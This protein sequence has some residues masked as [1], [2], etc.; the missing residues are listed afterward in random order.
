MTA[1]KAPPR[2]RNVARSAGPQTTNTIVPPIALVILDKPAAADDAFTLVSSRGGAVTKAVSE[3]KP[4]D[5]EHDKLPFPI[6]D[7]P[8]NPARYDLVQKRGKNSKNV[9]FRDVSAGDLVHKGE[10][11]PAWREKQYYAF[12]FKPPATKDKDLQA[13]PIDYAAIAVEEPI[14][15]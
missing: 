9:V 14:T 13:D 7:V 8:R 12:S 15:D 2:T 3:A 4:V 6:K 1:H 5:G 10:G 11:P